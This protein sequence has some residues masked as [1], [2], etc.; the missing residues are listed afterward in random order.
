MPDLNFLINDSQTIGVII[1]SMTQSTTGNTFLT[2]LIILFIIMIIAFI[3][4]I[5]LEYT[6]ILILPLLLSLMAYYGSFWTFGGLILI[7]L[8]IIS[9]K[10]FFFSR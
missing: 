4:R 1:N 9:A 3:F 2:Y 6:A 7:Y 8:A 5:R 10:H